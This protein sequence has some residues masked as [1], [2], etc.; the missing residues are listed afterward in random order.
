MKGLLSALLS[1]S[2]LV[3]AVT[4]TGQFIKMRD[5]E[6]MK[7]RSHI[8]VIKETPDKLILK[9]LSSDQAS[10]YRQSITRLNHDFLEAVQQFWQVSGMSV[11]ITQGTIKDVIRLRKKNDRSTIVLDC[12]SLHVRPTKSHYA[13]TAQTYTTGLNWESDKKD[14]SVPV[15]NMY[16]VEGDVQY[17]FYIQ[18]MSEKFPDYIDLAMGMRLAMYEFSDETDG[19]STAGMKHNAVF[20]KDRTLLLCREWLDDDFVE[21][22]AKSD[23][24]FPIRFISTNDLENYFHKDAFDSAVVAYIPAGVFSTFDPNAPSMEVHVPVVVDPGNGMPL[25]HTDI[26]DEMF[27]AWGYSLIPKMGKSIVGFRKIR[28]QDIKNFAKSY[29]E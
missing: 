14:L 22:A 18:N 7:K 20:L 11:T 9:Q 15:I 4:A 3:S 26:S 5:L 6:K 13:K 1:V 25:C 24:P 29:K 12:Q 19:H 16:F 23:Y 8:I 28:N 2:L 21:S 17:P 27:Q 10:E